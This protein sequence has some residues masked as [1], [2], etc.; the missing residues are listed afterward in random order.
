MALRCADQILVQFQIAPYK[1][2]FWLTK[3]FALPFS[4]VVEMVT[5]KNQRTKTL[6]VPP[7][8]PQAIILAPPHCGHFSHFGLKKL[9]TF[10]C[11][12]PLQ[13]G[14]VTVL[15]PPQVGHVSVFAIAVHLSSAVTAFCPSPKFVPET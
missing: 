14:Q 15:L 8:V 12:L 13:T 6:P 4:P 7:Q 2:R 9:P 5:V 1:L 11:P 10:T 3:R